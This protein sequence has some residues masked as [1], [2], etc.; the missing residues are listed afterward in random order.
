MI[1]NCLMIPRLAALALL[2]SAG[3]LAQENRFPAENAAPA[4]LVMDN[5]FGQAADS[6]YSSGG[7][8]F[9]YV[10]LSL[11]L[12]GSGEWA[13]GRKTLGKVFIGVDAAFWAGYFSTKQYVNTLQNDLEAYAALHAG[14]NSAG[15]DGQY[16]I[17]VGSQ[18]SIYRFNEAKLRERDI[19]ATYRE[20]A[21]YD[22]VWDSEENRVKYV[23]KRFE[24]LDWKR[25]TDLLV[26]ALILNRIVSAID[27]IRLIKKSNSANPERQSY[28]NLNYI[29]NPQQG[30]ALEVR[31][32]WRF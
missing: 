2:L 8:K 14:V 4:S 25:R 16:W 10:L 24:R 1:Y 15:K 20:G 6:Q 5:H 23:E 12:P 9:K 27:V 26:G 11:V 13:M 3:L 29:G 7:G 22:W 28:L 31:F 18:P 21:G 17:D 32:T 30:D 19:N